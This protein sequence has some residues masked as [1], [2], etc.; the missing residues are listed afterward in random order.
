LFSVI[1]SPQIVIFRER[2]PALEVTRE[3]IGIMGR[4]PRAT[5]GTPSLRAFG[6]QV[7]HYRERLGLSQE[8]ST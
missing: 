5:Y 4:K 6:N 3:R 2:P 7:R 1:T 8:R